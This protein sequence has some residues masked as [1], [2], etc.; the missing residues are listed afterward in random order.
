MLIRSSMFALLPIKDHISQDLMDRPILYRRS[1]PTLEY[2]DHFQ[3]MSVLPCLYLESPREYGIGG[4]EHM[5]SA[6]FFRFL[7]PLP[8][9][10]CHTHAAD[11]Y[12]AFGLPPPTSQCRHHMYMPHNELARPTFN[13]CQCCRDIN[14]KAHY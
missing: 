9:C 8:P 13:A 2:D 11:Q 5:T 6:Q 12:S 10:Y 14:N 4:H 3:L 7:D 1:Y